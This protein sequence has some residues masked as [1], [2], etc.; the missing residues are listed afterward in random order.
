MKDISSA[1]NE[2]EEKLRLALDT[3]RRSAN[4]I[5]I[6]RARAIVAS[7]SNI[8]DSLKVEAH[9]STINKEKQ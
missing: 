4:T 5:P 1:I 6:D 7:A 2:S 8:I 9:Q 3:L